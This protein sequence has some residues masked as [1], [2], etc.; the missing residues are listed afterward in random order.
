MYGI[1]KNYGLQKIEAL[2][3]TFDPRLHEAV[4]AREVGE[5]DHNKVLEVVRSG[6]TIGDTVLEPARVIIG[7]YKG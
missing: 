7:E 6:Y 5:G 1:L 4:S 3:Q 2:G